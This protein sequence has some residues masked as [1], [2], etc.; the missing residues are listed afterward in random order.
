[1]VLNHKQEQGLQLAVARYRNKEKYT[2]IAGY[3]GT[4]KA[5][6]V[7]T[8]IPTPNGKKQL[9]D[10]QLGDYVYDRQGNPTKVI[11]IYPQGKLDS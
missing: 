11:G 6:P 1:M 5:Q 2:V 4:G 9:G 8:I 7:D 3:A 10:I